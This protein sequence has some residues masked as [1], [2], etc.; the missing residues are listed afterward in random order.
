MKV[1]LQQFGIIWSFD[2]DQAIQ[3]GALILADANPDLEDYGRRLKRKSLGRR[4]WRAN[5]HNCVDWDTEAWTDFVQ[6]MKQTLKR[7]ES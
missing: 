1:Y 5:H 2:I 3:F 7:K 6:E 4:E